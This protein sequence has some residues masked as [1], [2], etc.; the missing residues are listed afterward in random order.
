MTRHQQHQQPR[1]PHRWD[2]SV[3]RFTAR[4]SL[5]FGYPLGAYVLNGYP[6]EWV[7]VIWSLALVLVLL[8]FIRDVEHEVKDT[9]PETPER[10]EDREQRHRNEL[11]AI[12]DALNATRARVRQQTGTR[13]WE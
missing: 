12:R 3:G 8:L 11:I 5:L 4:M 2:P 1:A 10:P 6:R 7:L 9:E 13:E